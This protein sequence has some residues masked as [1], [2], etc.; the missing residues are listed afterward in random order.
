MLR[1]KSSQSLWNIFRNQSHSS[2]YPLRSSS[3]SIPFGY[4][5]HG[6]II[7]R[8]LCFFVV[9]LTRG[10]SLY[11]LFE[12]DDDDDNDDDD[13]DGDDDEGYGH[14][15]SSTM[16]LTSAFSTTHIFWATFIRRVSC[17]HSH[18]TLHF[19]LA[20][21][22]QNRK[23]KIQKVGEPI[24][25]CKFPVQREAQHGLL[26]KAFTSS[27]AIFVVWIV[28][29]WDENVEKILSRLV[30]Y[31]L[32]IKECWISSVFDQQKSK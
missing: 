9:C 32:F 31:V 19:S 21:F 4:V 11:K 13:D 12:D 25:I 8:R 30:F 20:G 10:N 28:K 23:A 15:H 6:V 3:S 18:Q 2:S 17:S 24:L 27:H 7:R 14:L 29:N 1:S 26:G 5:Y 16:F 22:S